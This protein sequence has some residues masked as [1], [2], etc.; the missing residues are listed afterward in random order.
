[1]DMGMFINPAEQADVGIRPIKL[2]GAFLTAL[3]ESG[4][5]HSVSVKI[6][7][8]AIEA[9]SHRSPV[10]SGYVDI[11]HQLYVAAAIINLAVQ[12]SGKGPK[13]SFCPDLP[14]IT[15]CPA[16]SLKDLTVNFSGLPYML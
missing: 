13:L 1:M 6:S 5:G 2:H 14:G 9:A 4:Y 11:I 8:K 10:G 7:V 12:R 16:S 15:L 3:P